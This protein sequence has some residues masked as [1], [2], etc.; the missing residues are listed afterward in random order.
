V[1]LGGREVVGDTMELLGST[2]ALIENVKT[3]RPLVADLLAL[4]ARGRETLHESRLLLEDLRTLIPKPEQVAR[5]EHA[6]DAANGLMKRATAWI[7][8]LRARTETAPNSPLARVADRVGSTL[9]HALA[10]FIA[11]HRAMK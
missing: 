1:R 10:Y 8:S 7:G 5:L 3:L 2:E 4:E 6:V 11:P 9:G